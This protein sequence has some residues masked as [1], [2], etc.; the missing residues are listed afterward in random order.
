[1]L[2]Q[3]FALAVEGAGGFIE[4]QDRRVAQDGASDGE[5]LALA[6]RKTRAGFAEETVDA[7]GQLAEEAVGMGG[8]R[9]GPDFG[10]GG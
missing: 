1:M 5:A 7:V 6:A 10:L 9:S 8:F 2:D 4:Q 3:A